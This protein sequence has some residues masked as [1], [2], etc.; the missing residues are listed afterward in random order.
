MS[1]AEQAEAPSSSNNKAESDGIDK[2]ESHDTSDA[3]DPAEASGARVESVND[4]AQKVEKAVMSP[5]EREAARKKYE[6][7]PLKNIS[8]PHDHDVLYGR[9]GGTNHH[10]GNKRYRKMVED[11]KL[12]Y[13]NSKRLDKPLVALEIIKA[14]REQEPPGRFL[15]LDEKTG[16]WF[17]VGDKKAREKTSQAL[18][19]KAP[20][21]R[22][23]QEEERMA[24][25][26]EE[27]IKTTRFAEGTKDG[28]SNT[29]RKPGL[30]RD[31]SLGPLAAESVTT[32]DGFSWQDGIGSNEGTGDVSSAP[33]VASEPQQ[34]P[35]PP[36]PQSQQPPYP[37]GPPPYPTHSGGLP[38]PEYGHYRYPSHGNMGPPPSYGPDDR[39][40]QFTS[41]GRYESWGSLPPPGSMPSS[42][43]HS[44]GRLPS[45]GSWGAPEH[46][47][48]SREHSLGQFPLPHASIGH[49]APYAAFDGRVA[50][51]PYGHYPPPYGPP[52]YHYSGGAPPPPPPAYRA[53]PPNGY[54]AS[55]TRSPS[56]THSIDPA[57]ASAWSGRPE[58]EIVKTLSEEEFE[59]EKKPARLVESKPEIIKRATSN[60]NET[61]ETKPDRVGPSVKRAALNRDSSRASNRLKEI[62]FPGQFSNG[63]FDA[64][65]EMNEL[66]EDMNRSRLSGD[67]ARPLTIDEDDR[68]ITF[69]SLNSIGDDNS[70]SF[71][72]DSLEVSGRGSISDL[73]A[74]DLAV[75]PKP[76]SVT[77]R[78]STIEGLALDVIDDV[79]LRPE[80]AE[81]TT[82]MD[83]VMADLQKPGSLTLDSRMTTTDFLQIVNEPIADDDPA[84]FSGKRQAV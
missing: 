59:S 78:S 36:P 12:D 61:F 74:M 6:N 30:A 17:D 72:R 66:S 41:S 63:R 81:R 22:K 75:K 37:P 57:V 33:S 60:Q 54:N 79:L 46:G 77:S 7:W 64:A 8:E 26:G 52:V 31:T 34:P 1:K 25:E 44:A 14:W 76:L 42:P 68:K 23:Q 9:G 53:P 28:S 83:F 48:A 70:D 73:H 55:H 5:E 24:E 27:D 58:A 32:L 49:P 40:M 50:S 45:G 4:D 2:T 62:C 11:K 10:P 71:N 19:E 21:I 69:G 65:K 35:P 47:M 38:P 43:L 84:I 80:P 20:L 29:V 39:R 51:G 82:T 13:V 3:D 67:R 56:S 15:K 18:R 16:M